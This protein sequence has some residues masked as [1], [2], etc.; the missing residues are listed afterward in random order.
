MICSIRLTNLCVLNIREYNI[1]IYLMYNI[2]YIMN[3]LVQVN[4]S[5]HKYI[6]F[7]LYV[8]FR[9]ENKYHLCCRG[10]WQQRSGRAQINP[11]PTPTSSPLPPLASKWNTKLPQLFVYILLLQIHL[12]ACNVSSSTHQWTPFSRVYSAL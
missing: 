6:W 12:R 4:L 8:Y 7:I 3:A 9:D 5:L 10:R 11:S 1:C 2:Y